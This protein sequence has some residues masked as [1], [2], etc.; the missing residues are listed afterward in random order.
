MKP[1][2]LRRLRQKT[3][4]Y[5]LGYAGNPR[6]YVGYAETRMRAYV[7]AFFYS[8]SK[9]VNNNNFAKVETYRV[10]A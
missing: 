4:G 8:S 1:M 9:S 6:S 3:P 5:A 2:Q 10:T 7:R